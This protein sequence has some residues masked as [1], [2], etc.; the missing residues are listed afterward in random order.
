MAVLPA[1]TLF[2]PFCVECDSIAPN[3]P[4]MTVK[5]WGGLVGI[6]TAME[7]FGWPLAHVLAKVPLEKHALLAAQMECCI[8]FIL[9]HDAHPQAM[10]LRTVDGQNLTAFP[11]ARMA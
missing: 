8:N 10:A 2:V 6:L 3:A 4:A 7:F 9:A 11:V 5:E 1:S